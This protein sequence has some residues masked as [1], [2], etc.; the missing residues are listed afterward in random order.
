MPWT[1]GGPALSAGAGRRPG[2]R[3]GA[4]E[5]SSRRVQRGLGRVQPAGAGGAGR[6]V[7]V[8]WVFGLGVLGLVVIALGGP[9]DLGWS[10]RRHAVHEALRLVADPADQGDA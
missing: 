3:S 10:R 1:A 2:S 7:G 8:V 5:S 4:L 6:P 9:R